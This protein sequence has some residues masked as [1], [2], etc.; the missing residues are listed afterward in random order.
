MLARQNN[1]LA[2]R[3]PEP[4]ML[5]TF[6]QEDVEVI[7]TTIAFNCTESEFKLFMAVCSSTGLNPIAKQIY[8]IKRKQKDVDGN[9]VEKMTIQT[10]IDGFRLI[11]QRTGKYRG[12]VPTL[13]CGQDGQWKDVWLA[14]EPPAAAKVGVIH[15]DFDEP[16]YRVAKY[17]SYSSGKFLWATMPDVMI[18]KV[19]EAL[20]LRT[21]FPQELSGLYSFDEIN[22]ADKKN[23]ESFLGVETNYI[24]VQSIP[25]VPI[26]IDKRKL[27]EREFGTLIKKHGITKEKVLTHLAE[28]FPGR[29]SSKD[30][31]DEELESFL[32]LMIFELE[33]STPQ[34]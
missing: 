12:Q 7:K 28:A 19:A 22:Q 9:Y 23:V 21:A 6:S 17:K 8:P 24:D 26:E 25:E 33:Q 15:K 32:L 18:A 30:L 14:D 31:S 4:V 2:R 13:W 34:E 20:A 3:S 29:K 10:A 5:L 16:L 27:L 1:E 11:A